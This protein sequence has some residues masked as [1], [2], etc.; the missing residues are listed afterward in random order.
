MK[1]N[2]LMLF[3]YIDNNLEDNKKKELEAHLEQ[4]DICKEVYNI[5]SDMDDIGRNYYES[6][7][8]F[9][10]EIMSKLP[11]DD[12]KNRKCLFINKIS[13]NKK[14]IIAYSSAAMIGIVILGAPILSNKL[15][16]S[17]IKNNFAVES[18]NKPTSVDKNSKLILNEDKTTSNEQVVNLDKIDKDYIYDRMLNTIDFFKTAKGGYEYTDFD[19]NVNYSV[20]YSIRL[21]KNPKSYEKVTFSNGNINETLY[22][23][24]N[25]SFMFGKD[26]TIL[27]SKATKIGEGGAKDPVKEIN[28]KER[29]KTDDKGEKTYLYR[30]DIIFCGFAKKS[31]LPQERVFKFLSEFNNW[32]IQSIEEYNDLNC[33]VLVGKLDSK[34]FEMWVEV[35][36]GML[37]KY[38]YMSESNQLIEKLETKKIKL[39]DIIDEK[40]FEKDL[41]KYKEQ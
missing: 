21:D 31:L 28:S 26:M 32:S 41:S 23:G 37:L 40:D 8:D 38:Q 14:R 13:R 15:D 25:I 24:E 16:L 11:E 22:D 4:C 34:K 29:I 39:N 20:D 12:Y 30:Q 19:R 17:D 36:T 27:T 18:V 35:N 33:A 7:I 10:E 9:T 6:N 3:E 1:C 5:F 2:K